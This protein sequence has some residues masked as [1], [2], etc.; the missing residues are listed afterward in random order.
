M[1]KSLLARSL[2]TLSVF[3][4]FLM[5][6][7]LHARSLPDTVSGQRVYD[8]AGILS[9]SEIQALQSKIVSYQDTT[10]TQIVIFIGK[11]LEGEDIE[12]FNYRLGE[13]WG[14]GQKGKNNGIVISVF[15][16]DRLMRIDVGRGLEG[17]ITDGEA[18]RIRTDILKPSFQNKA[19]FS[20]LDQALNALFAEASGEFQ[21]DGARYGKKKSPLFFI[22][23]VILVLIILRIFGRGRG[24]GFGGGF[25]GGYMAGRMM[26]GGWGNFSSGG[27]GFGGG[28]F[29]GGSFGGGGSGGSW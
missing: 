7:P 25:A 8:E 3:V 29:G 19:Y 2:T 23:L 16:E 9:Q 5:A 10:S 21:G 11:S 27:G 24:G 26:G 17:A 6:L 4:L 28:G 12:G 22:V 13:T 1:T 18:Y 20:G 15:M 14:I